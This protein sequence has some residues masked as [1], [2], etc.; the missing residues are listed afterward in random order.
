MA[1]GYA[2]QQAT[3]PQAQGILHVTILMLS[4]H[5]SAHAA[6]ASMALTAKTLS[7]VAAHGYYY[8]SLLGNMA[9]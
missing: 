8:L 1:T 4:I 7:T 5:L 6:C 2:C 3:L 9:Q